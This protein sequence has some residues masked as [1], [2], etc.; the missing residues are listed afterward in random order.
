MLLLGD[1]LTVQYAPHYKQM[2]PTKH[3]FEV[4]GSGEDALTHHWVYRLWYAHP[5][6]HDTVVLQDFVFVEQT[7]EEWRQ[8]WRVLV[9]FCLNTG[10]NTIILVGSPNADFFRS[11]TSVQ[12]VIM[13]PPD[14]ADKIHYTNDGALLLAQIVNQAIGA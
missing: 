8:A 7:T 9:S 2:Q 13:P 12:Q 3:V 5:T 10:A 1:S 6:H 14:G 11:F 4:G